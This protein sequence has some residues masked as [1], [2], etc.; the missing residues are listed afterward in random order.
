MGAQS[1]AV[2]YL[3]FIL[4]AGAAIGFIVTDGVSKVDA[5]YLA[6][7]VGPTRASRSLNWTL[8]NPRASSAIEGPGVPPL[9][10]FT[11]FDVCPRGTV[12]TV[13]FGDVVPKSPAAK[14]LSAGLQVCGIGLCSHAVTYFGEWHA[15]L[16]GQ[17]PTLAVG[18]AHKISSS[19]V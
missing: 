4:V 16:L 7:C 5:I 11:G 9:A 3:F 14:A 19:L 17:R 8:C 18:N 15:R 12:T 10:L 2:V 6:L 1:E 13:G